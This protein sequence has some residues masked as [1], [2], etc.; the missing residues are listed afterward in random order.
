MRTHRLSLAAALAAALLVGPLAASAHA[1]PFGS[2]VFFGDS[3]TD[4][5]NVCA[6]L[7]AL[8]GGYA[9]GRCSNGPVWAD[10]LV[11]AL[12]LG[13]E[14]TSSASGGTNYAVGGSTSSSLAGQVGAY[15]AAGGGAAD[16]AALHVI[17]LG[18]N[19]VLFEGLGIGGGGA[20]AMQAAAERIGA[21]IEQLSAAGARYFAVANAP[22][23]GSA[24]GNPL[25]NRPIGSGT[26]PFGDAERERLRALAL[27]F[28]D[29]LEG[30]LAALS[31]DSLVAVDTLA[32]F[33]AVIADPAAYGFPSAAVDASDPAHPFALACLADP[34]CAADPG[35]AVADGYLIF[36]SIHPTTAF[37]RAIAQEALRL[38]VPE[39]SAALSIAAGL[40]GLALR[41]RG[42]IAPD[43]CA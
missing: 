41:R 26:V 39:P 25:L 14:A 29:A 13:D 22:D 7:G 36:D 17:W 20:G 3:L 38:V 19:D 27:E 4:T 21:G 1:H 9:A 33:D 18:G 31:V 35:G 8:G 12:G 6:T 11:Q 42:A 32:A 5:G 24:Y 15:L 30:V 34:V 37:H 10:H 2:L 23:V 43:A 40:L 28:N 16:P